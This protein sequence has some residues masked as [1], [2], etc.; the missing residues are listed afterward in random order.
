M[1]PA[2]SLTY[3]W[4]THLYLRPGQSLDVEAAAD[5]K[6]GGRIDWAT[7]ALL[8]LFPALAGLL[9]GF[10]IGATSGALVSLTNSAT[11]GTDW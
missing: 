3:C 10:D 5:E 7:T 9:F 6:A 2:A 11:S 1:H 4:L 8:F